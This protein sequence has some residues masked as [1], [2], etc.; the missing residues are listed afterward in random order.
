MGTTLIVDNI[1]YAFVDLSDKI[2]Y[3]RVDLPCTGSEFLL[4]PVYRLTYVLDILE[5]TFIYESF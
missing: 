1:T 2:K 4:L 5:L 3:A